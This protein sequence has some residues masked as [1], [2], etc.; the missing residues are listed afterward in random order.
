MAQELWEAVA[1]SGGARGFRRCSEEPRGR[2][3]PLGAFVLAQPRQG[4]QGAQAP[5]AVSSAPAGSP[6][7]LA[8]L[9]LCH[10]QQCQLEPRPPWEQAGRHSR[11]GADSPL[12]L[13]ACPG[14]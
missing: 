12:H 3:A 10:R 14:P 6:G 5:L 7:L 1:W 8:R 4:A 11:V 13:R 2:G 9:Q